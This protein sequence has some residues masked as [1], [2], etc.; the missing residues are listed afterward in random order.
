MR[1]PN[2]D[3]IANTRTWGAASPVEQHQTDLA[4]PF[5]GKGDDYGKDDGI[6]TPALTFSP[7]SPTGVPEFDKLDLKQAAD[8]NAAAAAA[9]A[10][11][12]IKSGGNA[13]GNAGAGD[14]D[15]GWSSD[16][17]VKRWA[18]SVDATLPPP[19][20]PIIE[21]DPEEPPKRRSPSVSLTIKTEREEVPSRPSSV[22]PRPPPITQYISDDESEDDSPLPTP[23][24]GDRFDQPR[25][26]PTVVKARREDQHQTLPYHADARTEFKTA[27]AFGDSETT[28]TRRDRQYRSQRQHRERDKSNVYWKRDPHPAFSPKYAAHRVLVK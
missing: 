10:A 20:E 9:T 1:D 28:E 11:A 27:S 8:A 3:P 19:P 23:K 2:R 12:A 15:G 26:S 5:F 25:E 18:Q 7:F 22:A 13:A 6:A 14:D 4:I 16:A 24:I 17:A 21:L